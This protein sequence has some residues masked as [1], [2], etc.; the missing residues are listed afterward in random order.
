MMYSCWPSD[1]TPPSSDCPRSDSCAAVDTDGATECSPASPASHGGTPAVEADNSSAHDAEPAEAVDGAAV[2]V[3]GVGGEDAGEAL[4][5]AGEVHGDAGEDLGDVGERQCTPCGR[6]LPEK[7]FYPSAVRRNVHRCRACSNRTI[8]KAAQKARKRN[9]HLR[10]VS[11]VQRRVRKAYGESTPA[12]VGVKGVVQSVMERCDWRSAFS[13]DKRAL[14]L[15]PSDAVGIKLAAWHPSD[16]V[17]ATEAEAAA[18]WLDRQHRSTAVT[19]IE[20]PGNT[21]AADEA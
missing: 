15:M 14:T 5:D 9:P 6:S 17:C 16:T 4:G 13:G 21:D 18:F 8:A 1:E 19:A 2:G 12:W 11:E 3:A 7:A 10:S 20:A